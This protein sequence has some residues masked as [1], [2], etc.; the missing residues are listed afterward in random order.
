LGRAGLVLWIFFP[1]FKN[2]FEVAISG[3]KGSESWRRFRQ[4]NFKN[5]NFPKTR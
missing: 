4:E 1:K 5:T 2:E 3:L